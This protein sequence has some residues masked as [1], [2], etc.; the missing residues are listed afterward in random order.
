M[1][2]VEWITGFRAMHEHAR[3][4]TFGSGERAAYLAAREELA[5][6]L[7]AAQRVQAKPGQSAREAL[8]VSRALQATVTLDEDQVRTVTLDLSVGGFGAL[9]ARP[10]AVGTKGKVTLRLPGNELVT[11]AVR[12]AGISSGLGSS[13]VAFAFEHIDPA[14]LEKLELVV[15]D[16]LLDQMRFE[17]KK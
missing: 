8:R 7:L 16:T 3:R 9:L 1:R 14:D 5:R 6:A 17:E 10:V 15:Y 11:G 12:V 13:R 2:L 4:G